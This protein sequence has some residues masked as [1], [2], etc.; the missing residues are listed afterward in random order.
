[1]QGINFK[2]LPLLL[3]LLIGLGL[4]SGQVLAN[5]DEE[6]QQAISASQQLNINQATEEQLVSL[7]GI[8]PAKASAIIE[9]RKSQGPFKSLEEVQEVNGIG[10]ATASDIQELIIF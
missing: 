8:G 1:M 9:M 6:Q 4:T 2:T 5:T 7:P 3:A 10:P